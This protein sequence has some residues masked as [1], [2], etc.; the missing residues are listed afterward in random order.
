[1]GRELKRVP[2]D[3]EWPEGKV[4]EG[5]HNP[6][7]A[8]TSTCEACGGGGCTT[9]SQRL[10]DLVRL[11]M[12]SGSDT[13]R[14]EC[15]PYFSEG[16]FQRT[17]GLLCSND[18]VEL[19][20]G[21]AGRTP[22]FMGHDS[23]DSWVT[24]RKIIAAAGLPEDWGTCQDCNGDGTIWDSPEAEQAAE[25]WE[26][27]EPPIGDGYQI[28]E[29]VSDGSPISSVFAT[30]EELAQH[31]AGTR[32]GADKGSS[33]ET[34]LKFINGPGWAPTMVMDENGFRAGPDVAF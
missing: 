24:K 20:T 4:W 31:M 14:G 16:P 1:M 13:L 3:F 19:T 15:H 6:H 2:L 11:L 25:D 23:C 28:W 29:T 33:Y 17:R 12:L 18:M 30:P 7:Y 5:Y 26:P 10:E 27:S 22:S 21:L 34:W 32:W 8:K 9:A